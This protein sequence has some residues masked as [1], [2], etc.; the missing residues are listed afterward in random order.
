[1]GSVLIRAGKQLRGRKNRFR[2]WNT[3][4]R[5]SPRGRMG[6]TPLL[7]PTLDPY[8]VNENFDVGSQTW[9]SGDHAFLGP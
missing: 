7:L 8:L 6:L 3:E 9:Y 1:M 5:G 2:E 4:D